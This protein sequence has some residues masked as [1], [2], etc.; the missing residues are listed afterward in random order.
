MVGW[1]VGY[2]FRGRALKKA[3]KVWVLVG[4]LQKVA[5]FRLESPHPQITLPQQPVCRGC[6]GAI[7]DR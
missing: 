5:S 6:F 7:S 1:M 2:T 3:L 4:Q